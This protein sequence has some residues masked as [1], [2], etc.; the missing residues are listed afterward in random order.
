[1]SQPVL[2]HDKARASVS[3]AVKNGSLVKPDYCE[4]C[5]HF[6][7]SRYLHGHHDDYSKPLEV[8]WLCTSCH[9]D[10]HYPHRK[11]SESTR[12][13]AQYPNDTYV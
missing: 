4:E 11:N 3:R 2:S 1:M 7:P 12:R 13:S 5:L 10:V 6:T 8:R 9:T